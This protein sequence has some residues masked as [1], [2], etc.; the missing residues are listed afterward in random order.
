VRRL[1]GALVARGVAPGDAVGVSMPN[2]PLHL[3]TLLA[4]ARMGAVSVAVH[5][6]MPKARKQGIIAEY[7]VA[8]VVSN[9]AQPDVDGVSWIVLDDSSLSEGRGAGAWRGDAEAR[10]GDWPC[11]IGLSSG[12]TGTRPKGVL[13]THAQL[14]S[15]ALLQQTIVNTGPESRF[16][17]VMDLNV[18]VLLFRVLRHL[19]A[20]SSV[21][22][23]RTT[24]DIGGLFETI[25]RHAVT[26]TM[27]SPII[28][29][30]WLRSLTDRQPRAP[31]FAN[32]MLGG[33][34][35][36][37]AL[38]QAIREKITPN[39]CVNYG[40]TETGPVALA[41][42]ELLLRHPDSVGRAVPW[43]RVQI[44][45]E[46]DRPVPAGRSGILRFRSYCAGD[47]Y[48]RNPEQSAKVF[49]NGWV[50]PG[51][52]GRLSSDGVLVLEARV[53]DVL[54]IGGVKIDPAGVEDALAEHA[55]V[56]E[57]AVFAAGRPE[58]VHAAVVMRGAFDEQAL[59]AFCR[60]R[61][62]P[63]S[64]YRIVALQELPRNA[65]GKVMRHELT[66]LV[67]GRAA[68]DGGPSR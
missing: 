26:H 33:G 66:A 12:T 58:R 54:N 57:A 34:R 46:E 10:G 25:D 42:P 44:V 59:I 41:D 62:G 64:P 24:K 52:A 47:G 21:V 5:P 60:D 22:F 23:P 30:N 9:R 3:V 32:L 39:L 56:V 48:Y 67:E 18:T 2:T 68:G 63:M 51:D 50:Y 49:R 45:D 19:L 29:S 27:A 13:R 40:A 55:D 16:L 35:V 37:L 14:L 17:V 53:D 8:A 6:L 43:G 1:A 20:G 31:G 65:M 11:R 7:G 38:Q 28:V 61:V 4:L 15:I 36:P